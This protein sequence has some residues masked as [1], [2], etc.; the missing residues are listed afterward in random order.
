[1]IK[2]SLEEMK[3]EEEEAYE[4]L[5]ESIQQGEQG[6]KMQTAIDHLD[7]AVSTIDETISSIEEAKD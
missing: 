4:S 6:K 2:D 5:P 3:G 1:M 7:S